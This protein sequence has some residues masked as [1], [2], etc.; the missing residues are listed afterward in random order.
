MDLTRTSI[1]PTFNKPISS[2]LSFSNTAAFSQA[3]KRWFKETP[4]QYRE[5][6]LKGEKIE[7]TRTVIP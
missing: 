7:I 1:E 4:L 3:F 6:K 5:S 2:R